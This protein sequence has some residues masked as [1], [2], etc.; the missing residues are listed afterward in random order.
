MF[1]F[2]E[3]RKKSDK[4]KNLFN[5]KNIAVIGASSKPNSV[6]NVIFKNVLNYNKKV[7]GINIKQEIISRHKTYKSIKDVPE[8]QID[9]VII[10]VP[11]RFVINVLKESAFKKVKFAIIISAGFKEIGNIKDENEIIQIAKLNNIR[12]IGPNVLGILD[13][14]SKLDCLF[15][16]EEE[17]KRPKKGNISI[18]SQSGTIGSAILDMLNRNN[19]GLSKFISYGNASDINESDL[20]EYLLKDKNTKY[21]LIYAEE[22]KNGEKFFKIAKKAKKKIIILKS[23][24]SKKGQE[25]VMSHTGALA[26]NLK[27]YDGI[28]KQLGVIHA[29]SVKDCFDYLKVITLKK[30][31]NV[32]VITNGGGYGILITDLLEKYGIIFKKISE[33]EKKSLSF[34]P[35]IASLRNPI[36]IIGDSDAER[37][38]KVISTIKSDL[39]VVVLLGQTPE[40]TKK[41]VQI[42]IDKLKPKKNKII[43]LSTYVPFTEMLK[44]EFIT[45]EYPKELANSLSIFF[46]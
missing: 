33:K 28:F 46:T 13:L 41:Q 42:I 32:L 8:K 39:Y 16:P 9:L 18:I 17:L 20:L 11:Q 19:L 3:I 12:I 25:A 30:P 36:D 37:Y 5:P 22:I 1:L 4:M 43:F 21:I 35:K 23:G 2:K 45:F 24:L 26:G 31:K 14:H 27:I 38:I 10:A 44:K 6:G 34:L 29:N 15:L 7:Y 40:I